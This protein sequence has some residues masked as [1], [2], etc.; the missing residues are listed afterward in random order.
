[1]PVQGVCKHLWRFENKEAVA[2]AYDRAPIHLGILTKLNFDDY[3]LTETAS[4]SPAPQKKS[5]RFRGVCCSTA[6]RE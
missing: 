5:S 3:E 1:M 2:R 4:A 6:A